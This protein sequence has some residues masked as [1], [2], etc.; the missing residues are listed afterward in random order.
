[1][2]EYVGEYAFYFGAA[3]IVLTAATAAWVISHRS[4]V[5][6]ADFKRGMEVLRLE[7]RRLIDDA[8][9]ANN[10]KATTL[11]EHFLS[12]TRP[13]DSAVTDLKARLARLEEHADAVEAFIAGPQKRALE[14]DART[15]A[16]LT[17]LEQRLKALTDRLSLIEQMIDEANVRDQQRSNSIEVV[18]SHLMNTQKQVDELFPRLELGDKARTDLGALIGLFV[19]QL[20][21]ININSA[22]TALRVAGLEGLRSKVTGLEE[23][24]AAFLDRENSRSAGNSTTNINDII[25]DPAPKARDEV[26]SIGTNNGSENAGTLEEPP[27]STEELPNEPSVQGG[28]RSD[29]GSANLHPA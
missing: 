14:E 18:N 8:R 19:K 15:D 1:L 10:R 4:Y 21:R 5:K 3:F 12:A 7:F 28:N 17:K 11:R 27:T 20:K 24:L 23:R 9:V 26:S 22:E 29:N 13:I 16:R 2:G 25:E 6:S